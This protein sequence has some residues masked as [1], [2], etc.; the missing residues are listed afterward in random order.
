MNKVIINDFDESFYPYLTECYERIVLPLCED[1]RNIM[2]D[3]SI[4]NEAELFCSSLSFK[5]NDETGSKYI[6][7]QSKKDED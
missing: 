1:L 3:T 5:M 6:G 7:D 2:L 4:T